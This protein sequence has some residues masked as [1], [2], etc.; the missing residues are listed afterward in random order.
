VNAP[1]PGPVL[2]LASGSPRRRMLL[3]EAGFSFRVVVPDVD[4]STAPGEA[5]EQ[6]VAR[7]ALDKARAA[8]G[9]VV[10]GQ[11]VLAADTVVAIDGEIL[12]KPRDA[13]DAVR[14]LLQ[15]GGRTHRVLTGFALLARDP[16]IE[17]R[18][19]EESR[20]TFRSIGVAEAKAY[21]ATGEPLDKAGSYAA[22]GE[23]ASFIARIDGSRS[24]VIGLP[25]ERL[26]PILE[27][28]GVARA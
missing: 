28:C 2:I 18:G 20:V 14:M 1:A 9:G 27:R 8:L 26:V 4:E 24:N 11:R 6:V 25:M 7:L 5:P 19:V 22:Q 3:G 10:P 12:G 16:E 15:L 17:E 23:G 21:V 13:A